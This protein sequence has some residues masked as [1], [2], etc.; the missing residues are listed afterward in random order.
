MKIKS[1]LALAACAFTVVASATS[2]PKGFTEDLDAA[3]AEA[4]TSGKYVYACFSG[5]DW[6]IWCKRLEGEVFSDKTFDFAGAVKDDY[7]LVFIDSPRDKSVLSEKAKENNPKLIKKFE[8]RGF[9]TALILDGEGK[10]VAS[11]GYRAGG[12]KNYAQYLKLL[13]KFGSKGLEEKQE[14]IDKKYFQ[15]TNSKT[16]DAL[17]PLQQNPSLE[18]FKNAKTAFEALVTELEAV[19]IDPA[20]ADIGEMQRASKIA[21][22]NR[23]L[24]MINRDLARREAKA[25]AKEAKK[26]K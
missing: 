1:I 20:D 7:I 23:F 5:S 3:I 12:A 16:N 13:K 22:L 4:K 15:A 11:T 24:G 14:A 10:Q 18:D 21:Q 25:K 19:K 26:D 9:P 8:V 17:K 6:C 2:T